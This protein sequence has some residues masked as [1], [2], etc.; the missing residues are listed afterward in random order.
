MQPCGRSGHRSDFL[1]VHRLI[2]FAVEVFAWAGYVFGEGRV[3]QLV[4]FFL[5]LVI[6]PVVKETDGPASGCRIVY[7]FCNEDIV[8]VFVAE[9][10][11]VSNPDL[12]GRVY[13]YVPEPGCAIEL[14]EKE[15]FNFGAGFFFFSV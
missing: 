6:R 14:A 4:Q 1:G 13:Q 10:K 15:N 8:V 12:A 9:I 7:Y 2:A 11:F 5:E 3:S